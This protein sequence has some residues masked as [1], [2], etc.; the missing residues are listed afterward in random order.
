MEPHVNLA[1]SMRSTSGGYAILLGAGASI[2]SGMP[3]AYDV[4]QEL[5]TQMAAVE[6]ETEIG[7][8]HAWYKARFGHEA[9]YDALLAA[10]TTT[11]FE[12]RALLHSFFEPD[13]GE[14]ERGMK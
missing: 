14:R 12:R 8:P 7:E 3:S 11:P 9:T 5:I 13:E 2:A 1:F 4:Q 10:L 6:G